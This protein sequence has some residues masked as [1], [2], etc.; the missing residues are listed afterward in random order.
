MTALQEEKGLRKKIQTGLNDTGVYVYH[1]LSLFPTAGDRIVAQLRLAQEMGV[2]LTQLGQEQEAEEQQRQHTESEI[3]QMIKSLH[4]HATDLLTKARQQRGRFENIKKEE[5]I[6]S[7]DTKDIEVKIVQVEKLIGEIHTLQSQ[8][9]GAQSVL[10]K[11]PRYTKLDQEILQTIKQKIASAVASIKKLLDDIKSDINLE[12]RLGRREIRLL[13]LFIQSHREVIASAQQ[14]KT[15]I[16]GV[17][18]AFSHKRE[19]AEFMEKLTTA[20]RA[21]EEFI[22]SESKEG[23]AVERIGTF[24]KERNEVEQNIARS[25]E[26]LKSELKSEG[27]IHSELNMLGT[28]L[29]DGKESL[30][31]SEEAIINFFQTETELIQQSLEQ[32]TKLES[33][34]D[35][36][37]TALVPSAIGRLVT[38]LFSKSPV[39][40]GAE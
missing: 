8:E 24:M 29:N 13:N 26:Q 25:L 36:V 27:E 38:R 19:A 31:R 3:K 35:D 28:R 7:K 6:S 1:H 33:A 10:S 2:L 11:D 39:Q 23:A 5:F 32:L 18:G 15:E 21:V 37:F 34:I 20:Q 9:Q 22:E 12:K 30:V 17:V 16:E 40:E 4:K 14:F